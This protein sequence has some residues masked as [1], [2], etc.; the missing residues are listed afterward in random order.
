[1]CQHYNKTN[2]LQIVGLLLLA[3]NGGWHWHWIHIDLFNILRKKVNGNIMLE[4][5][6]D[7]SQYYS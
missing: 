1:V 5:C 7:L 4:L 3:N 6:F 2:L